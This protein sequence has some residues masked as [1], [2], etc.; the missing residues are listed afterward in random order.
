LMSVPFAFQ[1]NKATAIKNAGLPVYADNAAALAG[2][3][4]AGDMY[5]TAAGILMIVF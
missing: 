4:V 1:A 3:L 2:G 5:R